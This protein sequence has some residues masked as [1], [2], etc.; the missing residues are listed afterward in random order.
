MV[1]TDIGEAKGLCLGELA[2]A[3]REDVVVDSVSTILKGVLSIN[4]AT[5]IGIHIIQHMLIRF[6]V[7]RNLEHRR[8]GNAGRGAS[9]G[10]KCN[11]LTPTGDHAGDGSNIV[12]RS[13]HDERTLLGGAHCLGKHLNDRA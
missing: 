2:V 4:D 6:P 5:H 13:I 12:P 10:G 11:Q 9:A 8:K 7:A 1:D 3:D